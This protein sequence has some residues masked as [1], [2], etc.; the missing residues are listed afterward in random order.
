MRNR[1]LALMCALSVVVGV[2]VVPLLGTDQAKAAAGIRTPW[3]EPDLQ[4]IWY[5]YENAPLER[6]AQYAGR[7]LLT[8]AEMK[9]KYGKRWID[10]VAEGF[11]DPNTRQGRDRRLKIGTDEDV[12][13]AYNAL[14]TPGRDHIKPTRRTSLIVDPPDGT[15]PPVTPD[16]QKRVDA[17]KQFQEDLLQ[18]TPMGKPGPLFSRRTEAPPSYNLGRLHRPPQ[19]PED[20]GRTERCLPLMMPSFGGRDY[21]RIVQSPGYVAIYYEASGHAG[22]NRVIP[23]GEARWVPLP[24]H[25]RQWDGDARG[26]WD[27]STLVVETTNF[28]DK[29]DYHGSRENLHLTE[30]FTRLDA[31][32]I[33]YELTVQDPTTWTRP[34]SVRA[35]MGKQNEYEN[36]LYEPSCAEGDYGLIGILSGA[37][38]ADKA[39]KEG[40]GP[41]PWKMKVLY[42]EVPGIAGPE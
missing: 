38:T 42:E 15:I 17:F 5:G 12:S 25:V 21:Q 8:D 23:V 4:G 30:R 18:G 33:R 11:T 32:T 13:G 16:G 37:R 10:K 7:E 39:F 9:A 35:D 2:S 14:W 20:R 19:G 1:F 29:T 34:W 3:G 41:D 22:A 31:D 24:P 40:R 27:G 26:R 6:P 36:G 28:T